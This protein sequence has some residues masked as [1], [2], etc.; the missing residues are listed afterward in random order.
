MAQAQP[1]TGGAVAPSFRCNEADGMW[2]TV[3][4]NDVLAS[5]TNGIMVISW[6]PFPMTRVYLWDR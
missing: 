6:N 4:K 2:R 3:D 5:L 1:S